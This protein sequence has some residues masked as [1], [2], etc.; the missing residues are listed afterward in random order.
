[1]IPIRL[2]LVSIAFAFAF[3]S[4][5]VAHGDASTAQVST[6]AAIAAPPVGPASTTVRDLTLA[7]LDLRTRHGA[8]VP[9]A[10][11]QLL[12]QLIAVARQRHD[13]L[14]AL[15]DLD[16]AEVLRVAIPADLLAG[17]PAQ[18]IPFLEDDVDEAGELEV[19]H[20]DHVNAAEDFYL[21][22][23]N[24]SK[25]RY[26]LHFA[27]ATPTLASGA[28]VRVH[29][30]RINNAIVVSD[31]DGLVV[32]KAV[33]VLPNTLGA[34][35]TLTILVNFSNAPTQPYTVA[36]A[37]AVMFTTTS[38]YDFEAS[39]QQTSLTG[40]VAGWFT[41]AETNVGCNYSTIAAQAKQA[42]SAAGYVLSN[43][44]RY[45]YVFPANG[46]GW[47]GL[48]SVGGNPS[49]AWIHTKY[50]FSLAVVGHEMG[51]NFGLYHSHSM[52]C[53]SVAVASSGC[54]TSD[55]GDV[56]DIMG[57]ANAAHFNAF[58]KERLGWLG[59]GVSPPLTTVPAQAGTTTYTI[60]P[61]EDA[62]DGRSRALKIP[63]GTACA[64]T[65]E[66]FYVESRQAKGFDSFLASNTNVLSGVLVHKVTEGNADSSYLL[67]LTPA[68]SSWSDAALAAGQTFTD[69]QTGL[70]IAP[71]SV[72]STGA[73]VNVTF[74]AASC[75]R[76]APKMTVTPTGTVWTAAGS[77]TNY[78]VSVT[79]QDSCG[80]A[81]TTYDV[82][83]SVPSGWGATNARTASVAPGAVAAASITVTT[84]STSP[85][86]FYN[87]NLSAANSSAPTMTAAATGTVAIVTA[88]SVSAT[89]DKASYVLPRQPNKAVTATITTKVLSSGNPLSGAAVRVDVRDP[90]GRLTTL[91]GTTASSGTVSV[92]YGMKGRNSPAGTY[93]V[94]S[95]ATMGT[96]SSTATTSFVLN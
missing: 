80:C 63:R 71:V 54:S 22:F 56:F 9:G 41:I 59:A 70:K 34:Q 15:V 21:H 46:C 85:A 84:A 90:A 79:N 43:Y 28:N 40:A 14:A 20:V 64:A 67:D 76:A 51:H 29:G 78:A 3:T 16:P 55:Y 49:Q 7:L 81:A 23:L 26:S 10:Q 2:L 30:R 69:P 92:S 91:T 65:N 44:N 62:R 66:W 47:W 12:A 74:P 8:A 94:T 50:G 36:T 48:G 32:T 88:L 11:G 5:A 68:T 86:A 72:T 18:A 45:V 52:D 87:V 60:A 83:A 57:T 58:Q 75:A 4:V 27:G 25:G 13:A 35:K 96:M 53:G 82:G 24:T 39:Y 17:M 31:T 73:L 61:I 37:Q 1:M 19:F 89:T 33:S 77:S 95:R 42:A 6:K 93:M 38:N